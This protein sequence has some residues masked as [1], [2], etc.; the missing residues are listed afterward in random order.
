M[1]QTINAVIPAKAGIQCPLPL[2]SLWIPAY[3]GMTSGQS[4]ASIESGV[5]F[6]ITVKTRQIT[7]YPVGLRQPSAYISFP[8]CRE[9]NSVFNFAV[10]RLAG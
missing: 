7:H 5:F 3:A 4:G 1:P 2:D 10:S 9:C 8:H 6:S